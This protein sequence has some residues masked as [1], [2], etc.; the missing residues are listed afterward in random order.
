MHPASQGRSHQQHPRPTVHVD[1]FHFPVGMGS[2]VVTAPTQLHDAIPQIFFT[3]PFE[4]PFERRSRTAPTHQLRQHPLGH[5]QRPDANHRGKDCEW[6]TSGQ[7]QHARQ[8]I[9]RRGWPGRTRITVQ[10]AAEPSGQGALSVNQP[11]RALLD[12]AGGPPPSPRMPY[13][14]GGFARRATTISPTSTVRRMPPVNDGQQHR[15]HTRQP[16]PRTRRLQ[17]SRGSAIK[18]S[19]APT[20]ARSPHPARRD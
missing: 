2:Q 14:H 10:P 17:H 6:R 11:C 15:G 8:P 19:R 4:Y 1:H 13:R 9:T 5:A 20:S 18:P 3:T 16:T 12:G 7:P